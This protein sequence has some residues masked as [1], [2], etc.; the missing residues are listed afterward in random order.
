VVRA[1]GSGD[2][3]L[4][5]TAVDLA[6]SGDAVLA[7][8]ADRGLRGRLPAGVAAVGP[9]WLYARLDDGA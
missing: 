7:V 8:T 1:T 3:A 9:G 5:A 4:A 6:A 2:D